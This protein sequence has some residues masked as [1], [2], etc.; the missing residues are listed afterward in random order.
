MLLLVTHPILAIF[1]ALLCTRH[2]LLTMLYAWLFSQHFTITDPDEMII[3]P[4]VVI[5]HDMKVN[6]ENF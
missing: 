4:T 5:G 2:K 3:S 1:S 6:Q